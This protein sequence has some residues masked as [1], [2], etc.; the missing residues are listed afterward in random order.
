MEIFN[1]NF[2]SHFGHWSAVLRLE[3]H[4]HLHITFKKKEQKAVGFL[5]HPANA[6]R[7]SLPEIQH[8][9]QAT[10]KQSLLLGL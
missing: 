10:I 5:L 9:P 3:I 8:G 1:E 2:K 4:F 6:E 7:Q